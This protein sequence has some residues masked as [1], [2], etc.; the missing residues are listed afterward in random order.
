MYIRIACALLFIMPNISLSA[1]CQDSDIFSE[2]LLSEAI[3]ELVQDFGIAAS[4]QAISSCEIGPGR[5]RQI[6]LSD[7]EQD[8]EF[9]YYRMLSCKVNTNPD[10][11]SCKSSE[12][13]KIKYRGTAID[14]DTA[15]SNTSYDDKQTKNYVLAL[16]CFKQGLQAGKV[17]IRKYNRLLDTTLNIP[18]AADSTINAIKALAGFRRYLV[19]TTP[20]RHRFSVELDKEYGCFIEPLK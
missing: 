19:N 18:L 3:A 14:T 15:L 13:R 8:E 6:K 9:S 5:Q 12:G 7:H 4:T 17:K 16:N 1:D 11:I 2:H 20:E 10:E